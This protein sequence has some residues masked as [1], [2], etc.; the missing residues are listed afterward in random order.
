MP[1]YKPRGRPQ[2]VPMSPHQHVD[3]RFPASRTMRKLISSVEAPKV[4]VGAPFELTQG[5]PFHIDILS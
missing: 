3:L 4:H 1:V 5:S 2:Q